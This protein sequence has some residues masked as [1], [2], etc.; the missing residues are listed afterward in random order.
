MKTGAEKGWLLPVLIVLAVLRLIFTRRR[1]DTLVITQAVPIQ[2]GLTAM[3]C[4][5]NK[6]MEGSWQQQTT[7]I[8][9]LK[10]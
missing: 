4:Q 3:G 10:T 7:D 1:S 2:I 6:Q 8:N 5:Y 9:L